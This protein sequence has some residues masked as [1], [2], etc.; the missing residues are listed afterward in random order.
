MSRLDQVPHSLQCRS[1]AILTETNNEYNIPPGIV[2]SFPVT[3]ENGKITIVPDIAMPDPFSRNLIK[4]TTD[5]L[6]QERET[7][8][9]L[10]GK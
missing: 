2:F 4:I 1:F 3:V 8:S 6:L 9:K 5:E 10:L 7:V